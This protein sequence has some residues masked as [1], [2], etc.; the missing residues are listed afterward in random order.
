MQNVG[1]RVA[2]TTF[3]TEWFFTKPPFAEVIVPP[4]EVKAARVGRALAALVPR[5]SIVALQEVQSQ[6]EL[7]A[8][9]RE[10]QNVHGLKYRALLGKFPSKRTGQ[11]VALLVNESE[12]VVNMWNSFAGV[13]EKNVW[14]DAT[15]MSTGGRFFLVNAHLKADFDAEN[16]ALREE[17]SRVL[18]S[19][20][21]K[22]TSLPLFVMGDLNDFDCQYDKEPRVRTKVLETL[23][24]GGLLNV[25][26]KAAQPSTVYGTR[27]DHILYNSKMDLVSCEVAKSD[28]TEAM[29]LEERTSDHYPVHA[30]LEFSYR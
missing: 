16:T 26:S 2:L 7:S 27:I 23:R 15:M 19:T 22:A 5:P 3:N 10:L 17:E 1:R 28:D 18:R 25:M 8:L 12:V 21:A 6:V 14:M 29:K 4:V 30:V 9:C 13:L 24:E 11:R 20:I